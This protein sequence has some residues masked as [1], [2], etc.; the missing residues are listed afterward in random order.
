MN[1]ILEV[2]QRF[3]HLRE[4]NENVCN[5]RITARDVIRHGI[6]SAYS[7]AFTL[8]MRNGNKTVGLFSA[9]TSSED[10]LSAHKAAMAFVDELFSPDAVEEVCPMLR[11]GVQLK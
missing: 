2:A 1:A 8:A 6:R 9:T 3:T 7:Y 5:E 11:V 4:G 10:E